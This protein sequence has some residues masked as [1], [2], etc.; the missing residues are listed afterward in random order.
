[1]VQ[2]NLCKQNVRES[3]PI[4][5]SQPN[6]PDHFPH[7]HHRSHSNITS[8]PSPIL[9][10]LPHP[11]PI[12]TSK[13]PLPHRSRPP[14]PLALHPPHLPRLPL[15]PFLQRLK[16]Q[17][18][19]P[20]PL[21]ILPPPDRH[22]VALLLLQLL[23]LEQR[24]LVRVGGF[25]PIFQGELVEVVL[26]AG[27]GVF[28]RLGEVVVFEEHEEGWGGGDGGEEL[29]GLV[30]G[31]GIGGGEGLGLL[32]WG[33]GEAVLG[34]GGCCWG[35]G[36]EGGGVGLERYGLL[37]FGVVG[38]VGAAMATFCSEGALAWLRGC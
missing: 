19:L 11:S 12:N 17:P 14:T 13:P 4:A 24:A 27:A 9:A 36:V 20:R 28:V 16:P 7:L 29:G 26:A 31:G 35:V 32:G 30:G 33:V 18:R 34:V 21:I 5:R 22:P 25:G 1:M 15:R 37:V 8:L 38:R 23:R 3:I 6:P 10:P 2:K